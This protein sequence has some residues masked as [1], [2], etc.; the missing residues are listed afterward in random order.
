M[1]Q[2]F[3]SL[4]RGNAHKKRYSEEKKNVLVPSKSAFKSKVRKG[5]IR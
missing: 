1:I 3:V 4:R 2:L 5:E